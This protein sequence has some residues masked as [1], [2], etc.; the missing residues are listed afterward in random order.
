M[1]LHGGRRNG[2]RRR[3]SRMRAD[4]DAERLISR[5]AEAMGEPVWSFVLR[6]AQEKAC[7]VLGTG[8][9]PAELIASL[10]RADDV[11]QV[12]T[13]IADRARPGRTS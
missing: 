13:R 1:R 11:P 2:E 6:A 12:F 7:R 8:S 3:I 5:A 9:P 10:D 4:E